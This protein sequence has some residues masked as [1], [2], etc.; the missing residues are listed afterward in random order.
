MMRFMTSPQILM[1]VVVLCIPDHSYAQSIVVTGNNQS[2]MVSGVYAEEAKSEP[3]VEVSKPEPVVQVVKKTQ[4]AIT[5][6]KPVQKSV[7]VPM[8]HS[9]MVATHNRLHGGGSWTWPGD[10]ATHLR[11]V[12]GVSTTKTV[13]TNTT[14]QTKPTTKYVQPATIQRSSGCPNGVCPTYRGYG[15]SRRSRR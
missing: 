6:S 1:C 9:E 5:V 13:T 8:S 3:V 7:S 2:I 12:H 4:P 14:Q 10:L 15:R 11:N